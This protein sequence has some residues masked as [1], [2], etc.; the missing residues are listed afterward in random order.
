MRKHLTASL[1]AC[2]LSASLV[3]CGDEPKDVQTSKKLDALLEQM[4]L[5]QYADAPVQGTELAYT[6]GQEVDGVK[7]PG[8]TRFE[9]AYLDQALALLPLADEIKAEGTD[10][11]IQS[12]NAIIGSIR[13]DE[14]AFL[15]DEAERAFHAEAH[16]VVALRHKLGVL[17]NIQALNQSVAGE[18]DEVIETYRTGMS[19]GG[20]TVIG[21]NGLE[22]KASAEASIAS[23]A[24]QDFA[25]YN[26][27]IADLREKVSEY[28]SLELKLTS[29]ARSS[30]APDKFDKLDQATSAAKEAQLAQAEAQKFEIDAW[31]A[32]RTANLA[33]FKREQLAG[34]KQSTTAG[35]LAKLNGFLDQA[36]DETNIPDSSG[37]YAGVA[38][39]LEQA[40]S[41]SGGDTNKAAAF[42]LSL[43]AYATTAAPDLNDRVR[44]V[45]AIDEQVNDYL[46]V[47]GILEMK[48]AQIKLDRQRVADKLA[49]IE[50]DRQDVI[51]EF[52]ADFEEYDKTMQA[53]AFDRMA[54]AIESLK[55]AQQAV[56]GSGNAM[57]M[58]LMSIYT[59]YARALQ[60]Q[61]VSARIYMTGLS[62]IAAAGS[63]LL[64][65]DLHD[66]LLS[67]I[68]DMQELLDDVSAAAGVLQ[69]EAGLTAANVVS[70]VDT[71]SSRGQIATNQVDVYDALIASLGPI[72]APA[73]PP[74]DQD[75]PAAE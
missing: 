53:T 75:E 25:K 28:E 36:S 70:G 10:L 19:I 71:E 57:D 58:E 64:G 54:K 27:Q 63:E 41:E 45:N 38:Q 52:A 24:S 66:T 23:Q 40:K 50:Q 35:L 74:A 17:R 42:L 56:E 8:S 21:I 6:L 22:E 7:V 5:L 48:I 44:L 2:L 65:S 49:E 9:A 3:G 20:A 15:I 29:Q 1:T 12:V 59:L 69:A 33:E 26:D 13:T 73:A 61:S 16:N 11:Q 31:I 4:S 34:E 47:I 46:G 62:S 51:D 37:A 67:R 14:A 72:S 43:S 32:E 39:A 30:K 18:R 55:I 68:E 60:Q